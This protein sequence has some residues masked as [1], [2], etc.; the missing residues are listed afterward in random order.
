MDKIINMLT[1]NK[2]KILEVFQKKHCKISEIETG[3][4]C[5]KTG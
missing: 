4:K 2:I 5:K 3:L 1:I